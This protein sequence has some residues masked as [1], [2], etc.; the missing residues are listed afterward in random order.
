MHGEPFPNTQADLAISADAPGRD[1]GRLQIVA[2]DHESFW[3]IVICLAQYHLD[4]LCRRTALESQITLLR[5]QE[6]DMKKLMEGA[7]SAWFHRLNRVS[8]Y[9]ALALLGVVIAVVTFTYTRVRS[10]HPRLIK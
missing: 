8:V 6:L 1:D 5:H 2:Q 4:V 10:G 9:L 7:P 3:V